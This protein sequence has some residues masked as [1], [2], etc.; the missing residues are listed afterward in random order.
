M[1]ATKEYKKMLL[2]RKKHGWKNI[3]FRQ[4]K[5]IA[6]LMVKIKHTLQKIIKSLKF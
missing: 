2:N 3:T 1:N 5:F 6:V 4:T